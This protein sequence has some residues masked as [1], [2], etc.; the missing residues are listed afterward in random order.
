MIT[1]EFFSDRLKEINFLDYSKFDVDNSRKEP[2]FPVDFN[3]RTIK[4][5]SDFETIAVVGDH[6]SEL[7]WFVFNR[8]FDGQD[9]WSKKWGIQFTVPT[10]PVINMMVPYTGKKTGD[11]LDEKIKNQYGLNENH[12]LIGWMIT[13]D[14]TVA[15]GPVSF[16]LRCFD[17]LPNG[18]AVV[19][20]SL[21]TRPATVKIADSHNLSQLTEGIIPKSD[22][23]TDLVARIENVMRPDGTIGRTVEWNDIVEGTLP[24]INNQLLKDSVTIDFNSVKNVSSNLPKINDTIA[25]T[26]N[27]KF[28]GVTMDAS[29]NKLSVNFPVYKI[30]NEP[31]V[32]GSNLTIVTEADASWIEGSTNPVQ[33]QFLKAEIDAI[34]AELG[35]LTYVPLSI[36]SFAVSP[37]MAE[38]GSI[39]NTIDFDWALSKT[40]NSL[41]IDETAINV[42]ADDYILENA[43][44]SS[45]TIFTLKAI[46]KG[47]EIIKTANIR[48][49]NKVYWGV[50][51]ETTYDSNFIKNLDGSQLDSVAK[52]TVNAGEG[53]YIYFAAPAAYAEPIFT[54]QGSMGGK[55]KVVATVDYTNGSET[56]SY[57]VY[58]SDYSGLGDSTILIS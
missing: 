50:S 19:N 44:I 3:T 23:L 43:N 26:E 21:S 29:S 36:L 24:R 49:V 4:V 47:N 37:S 46:D 10:K 1:S 55:W 35:E 2:V 17:V 41:F 57:K 32:D 39:I 34:K 38:K 45:D 28:D 33:S 18:T 8:Y 40:P 42:S 5:P 15:P 7:V 6:E 20:Y 25:L 30:N 53:Q 48:F 56:T 16:S 27:I 22:A 11:Q 54:L 12:L 52:F 13:R 14:V 9:L 58:Q 51:S 31:L